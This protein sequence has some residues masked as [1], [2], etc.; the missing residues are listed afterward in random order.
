MVFEE[1][2]KRQTAWRFKMAAAYW[3]ST[4]KAIDYDY[5]FV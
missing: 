4:R 2:K 5:F 1:Y 3:G